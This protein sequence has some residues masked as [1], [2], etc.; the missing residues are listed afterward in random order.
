MARF[1]LALVAIHALRPDELRAFELADL[2]LTRARLTVPSTKLPRM[3]R[4]VAA[5]PPRPM[6]AHG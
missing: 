5:G 4:R 1:A 3:R 2:D 6:A